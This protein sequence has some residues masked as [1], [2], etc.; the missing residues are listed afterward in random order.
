MAGANETVGKEDV[1]KFII[2]HRYLQ[3]PRQWPSG[4]GATVVLGR[5]KIEFNNAGHDEFIHDTGIFK[6]DENHHS[7]KYFLDFLKAKLDALEGTVT[8]VIVNLV[9]N[10]SPCSDCVTRILEFVDGQDFRLTFTIKFANFYKHY[11]NRNRESMKLLL[12]KG[13]RLQLLQGE[14]AWKEFLDDKTFVKLNT[15]GERQEILNLAKTKERKDREKD[16][17]AILKKIECEVFGKKV[18]ST[19]DLVHQT[20]HLQL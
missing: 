10:Y 20:Q 13:I 3:N 18:F 16:D 8:Q 6:N 12:Q 9:Q 19:D 17:V 5:V 14:S 4:S 15:R 2:Q 11:Y 1:K 7:E